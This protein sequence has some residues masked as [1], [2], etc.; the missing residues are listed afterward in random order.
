MKSRSFES[1]RERGEIICCLVVISGGNGSERWLLV[2]ATL[3][4][5]ERGRE[6]EG[7]T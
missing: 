1:C 3:I 5:A 2:V 7:G 4:C 6:I